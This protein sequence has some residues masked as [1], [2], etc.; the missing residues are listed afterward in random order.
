MD[1]FSNNTLN[2]YEYLIYIKELFTILLD[3]NSADLVEI[4][5][6]RPNNISYPIP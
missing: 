6:P 2:T 3:I 5:I 1:Y 4:I